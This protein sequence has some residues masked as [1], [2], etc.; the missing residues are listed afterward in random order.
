M[1]QPKSTTCIFDAN[2]TIGE[3]AMPPLGSL[4]CM[5]PW[6]KTNMENWG[7]S[8]LETDLDM[9]SVPYWYGKLLVSLQE[10]N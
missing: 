5:V 9:L 1:A 8:V 3:L 4:D 10:G 6:F 7:F 2:E